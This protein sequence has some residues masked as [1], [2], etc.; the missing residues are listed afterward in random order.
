VDGD[1]LLRDE[2]DDLL[3]DELLADFPAVPSS[4]PAARRWTC[5]R[6]TRLG[7]DESTAQAAALLVSELATNAVLHT[8][9]ARFTVCLDAAHDIEIAVLDHDP[10]HPPC[11][12]AT[13]DEELS[14][15]GLVLVQALSDGWGVATTGG[16][17]VVWTRLPLPDRAP[18]TG[19]AP[20]DPTS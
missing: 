20:A 4:V 7:V 9:A 11:T 8:R 2:L 6:L 1:E 5:Q 16:G 13:G 12:R 3:R 18:S 15:R 10:A 19:L 17:K 14:G